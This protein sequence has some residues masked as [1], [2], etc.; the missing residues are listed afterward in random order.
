[1]ELGLKDTVELND[2]DPLVLNFYRGA[3]LRKLERETKIA[4]MQPLRGLF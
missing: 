1:M 3:T 4:A 2:L